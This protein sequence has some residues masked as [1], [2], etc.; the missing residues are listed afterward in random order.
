[1][2]QKEKCFKPACTNL[3]SPNSNQ[4][5]HKAAY[6]RRYFLGSAEGGTIPFSLR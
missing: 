2:Q 5:V 4:I 3:P 6:R 1:M